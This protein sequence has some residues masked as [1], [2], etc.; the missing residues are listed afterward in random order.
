MPKIRILVAT[1]K[2]YPMPN[3][4]IYLPVFVGAK[5]SQANLVCQRDDDGINIS[6][7][8]PYY[9]ELTAIYWAWKNPEKINADYVGL[10]HYRRHFALKKAGRT[11]EERIANILTE[12]Q[13]SRA[14]KTSN[15]VL[16]KLR[17][18]YIENLYDHYTH[19]MEPAPLIETEKIIKKL[20]PDYLP[21]FR[22]L[23]TRTSAHMFNMFIMRRDIFDN[24]CKWLF[25][26]LAELEKSMEKKSKSY[27]AFQA[28]FY[29]RI[30]ELL[31]D[32]YLRTNHLDYTEVGAIDIENINWIKKGFSFIIAKVAGKKYDKSF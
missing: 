30:S 18:Y 21:E 2:K 5:N 25:D 15:I 6:E 4:N 12:K 9:C 1:H 28:R 31:L 16:P 11:P 7:K 29:G 22:N 8:N 24:Y 27:N 23:H 10:A 3:S 20:Y 17:K 26:I 32:V 19:T 13:A 14:L